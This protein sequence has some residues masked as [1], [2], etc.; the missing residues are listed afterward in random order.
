MLAIKVSTPIRFRVWFKAAA[1]VITRGNS[2][3]R[4][5]VGMLSVY[6]VSLNR[7]L[8]L[9]CTFLMEGFPSDI[10]FL[11][12]RMRVWFWKEV[13]ELE[14]LRLMVVRCWTHV[15][16]RILRRRNVITQLERFPGYIPTSGWM[17]CL[18]ANQRKDLEPLGIVNG[19]R[20]SWSFLKS[21]FQVDGCGSFVGSF[22]F[23][24]V[25]VCWSY[26]GVDCVSRGSIVSPSMISEDFIYV[27]YDSGGLPHE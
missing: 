25:V 19:F 5:T 12:L 21:T 15:A 14:E 16:E 7:D 24:V 26:G 27:D 9:S 10:L 2:L 18:K 22:S 8:F 6:N 11:D 20:A 23:C 17:V 13:S 3:Q 1:Q 4:L